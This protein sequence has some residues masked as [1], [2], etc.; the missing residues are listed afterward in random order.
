[1]LK[2]NNSGQFKRDFKRCQKQGLDMGLLKAVIMDLA[3]P[4]ELPEKNKDH[5][6]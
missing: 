2:I 3:K 6:L 4:V 5:K 1:M